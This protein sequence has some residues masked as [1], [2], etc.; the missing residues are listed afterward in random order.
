MYI[1]VLI[2]I[3]GSFSSISASGLGNYQ[4]GSWGAG[5]VALNSKLFLIG[6]V[7]STGNLISGSLSS[8]DGGFNP[9]LIILT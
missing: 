7:D 9:A 3:I 4:S 1:L 2:S 8:S 5:L 6:G